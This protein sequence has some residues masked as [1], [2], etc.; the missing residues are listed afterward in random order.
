[1]INVATAAKLNK[2][3]GAVRWYENGISETPCFSQGNNLAIFADA[4]VRKRGG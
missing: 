3:G 2:L 1:M 4:Q